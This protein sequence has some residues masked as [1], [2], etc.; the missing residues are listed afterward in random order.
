M[1]GQ[2]VKEERAEKEFKEFLKK[3][4]RKGRIFKIESDCPLLQETSFIHPSCHW[5]SGNA[6]IEFKTSYHNSGVLPFSK[7]GI[8]S[9]QMQN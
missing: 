3:S 4:F 1:K 2:T 8:T 6:H 5:H 9:K 7:T